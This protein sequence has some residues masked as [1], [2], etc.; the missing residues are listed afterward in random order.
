MS[1]RIVQISDSHISVDHPHRTDELE[2]CVHHINALPEQPDLVIHTGDV[3]HDGLPAEY[4]AAK[5]KL[6][7]LSAPY[8]VMAGN[9][10]NRKELIKKFENG[11]QIKPGDTW[12]QYAIEDFPT[13]FLA[14][15]TVSSDSN[16]G[17]LCPERLNH[18][19]NMLKSDTARPTV[20]FMHHPPFEAQGVPDPYQYEN[21]SEV[22]T[23]KSVLSAY[24]NIHGIY[25]GHVHR[26]IDSSVNGIFASALTCLASD[27]RKGDVSDTDRAKPVLKVLEL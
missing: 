2:R 14:I 23:L 1:T 15:D 21:W 7:Q 25:C 18:L 24:D 17:K 10:D 13:R 8:Y 4:A 9:R 22:D 20:L 3:A 16:K 19:E 27:L 6:D 12:V 26:N 5:E 11:S